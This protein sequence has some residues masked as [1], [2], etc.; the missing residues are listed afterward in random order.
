MKNIPP[1]MIPALKDALTHIY[2]YKNGLRDFL[3]GVLDSHLLKNINWKL[4]KPSKREIVSHLIDRLNSDSNTGKKL[5]RK[6]CVEVSKMDDFS[7]LKNLEDGKAKAEKAKAL[8]SQLKSL[9]MQWKKEL[10]EDK[11]VA[12]KR[13]IAQQKSKKNKK[14]QENLEKL[15]KEYNVLLIGS[16]CTPQQRGYKLEQLLYNTFRL[17]GLDS[18]A[19]FKTQGEQID[20]GFN[21][22]GTNYIIEVKWQ[23]NSVSREALDIFKSKIE[24]KLENTLG[25]FL[26]IN[27]FEKASIEMYSNT[28][29]NMILMDG[30]DLSAVLEER[31]SLKDL[32]LRKKEHASQTGSVFIKA[33][34]IT[35]GI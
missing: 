34:E 14:F 29:S 8:V 15:K 32:I 9:V 1:A 6:L 26:S 13:E 3:S 7:H 4:G 28:G 2:W 20:G 12:K 24:R 17:F 11:S 30:A 33:N 27:G 35:L 10:I 5:I 23:K 16:E 22:E 21:L 25:L 31:I 19:S 18:K